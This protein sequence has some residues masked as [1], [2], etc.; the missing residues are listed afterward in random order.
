MQACASLEV[1][2]A[3]TSYN[4]PKGNADTE[5]GMRTL[6]EECLWLRQWTCPFELVRALENWITDYNEHDL[7]AALGY[8]PSRHF[9]RAY[10]TSHSTPFVA[11]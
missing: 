3:F 8:K 5:R 4:N 6:Q 10:Y 1:H 9:E 7:H 11:A 2:Q